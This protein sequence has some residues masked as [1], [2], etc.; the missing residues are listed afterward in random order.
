MEYN[1]ENEEGILFQGKENHCSKL[2]KGKLKSK[3]L[4]KITRYIRW[5]RALNKISRASLKFRRHVF[6][7]TGKVVVTACIYIWK[8]I[9][10]SMPKKE[11]EAKISESSHVQ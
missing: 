8:K 4:L 9:V 11:S 2:K 10:G 6:T 3:K 7:K 5:V 1:I